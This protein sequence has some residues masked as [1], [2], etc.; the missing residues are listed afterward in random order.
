MNKVV[1]D[2]AAM[3]S[4]MQTASE[5]NETIRRLKKG[6]YF[7][8]YIAPEGMRSKRIE[9]IVKKVCRSA[10][11]FS[12][13]PVETHAPQNSISLLFSFYL[14]SLVLHRGGVRDNFNTLVLFFKV[15][16]IFWTHIHKPVSKVYKPLLLPSL[17]LRGK[18]RVTGRAILEQRGVSFVVV[19]EAHFISSASFRPAFGKIR[20]MVN[21]WNLEVG[22]CTTATLEAEDLRRVKRESNMEKHVAQSKMWTMENFPDFEC[23]DA[24]SW[25]LALIACECVY[26]AGTR[27]EHLLLSQIHTAII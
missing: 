13:N 3:I 5:S 19:D 17:L 14:L 25:S 9:Q 8:L 26:A 23:T 1:P 18:N 21:S 4:S 24:S 11:L 27:N 20:K 16:L 10:S 22:L 6:E 12:G 2:S 15:Y 7:L